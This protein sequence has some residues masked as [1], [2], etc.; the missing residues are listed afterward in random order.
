MTDENTNP[1]SSQPAPERDWLD[2]RFVFILGASRS[3]TTW[4]QSLLNEHPHVYTRPELKVFTHYLRPWFDS[5]EFDENDPSPHGLP[6]IWSREQFDEYVKDFLRRVY[7]EVVSEPGPNTVILEKI[8]QANEIGIIES[9]IPKPK[10]IHIIRDGRD[11]AASLMQASRGW[12][13]V[14]APGKI[15]DAATWW[16]QGLSA[17]FKAKQFEEEGRYLDV[18]YEDLKSDGPG[19]LSR[20]RDFLDFDPEVYDVGRVIERNRIEKLRQS[21]RFLDTAAL[22]EG[23]IRTGRS[24]TGSEGWSAKQRYEFHRIAGY[25]LF[26]LGYAQPGWYAKHAYQRLTLPLRYKLSKRNILA[27]LQGDHP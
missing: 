16:R 7:R 20:I 6:S 21:D 27:R 2:C 13:Q 5:W 3:G 4:L 22:P 10:Y 24:G 12:G 26:E 25:L 9:L 11:V 17:A 8:P 19:T 18:R 14:W 15:E 1:V 23:F